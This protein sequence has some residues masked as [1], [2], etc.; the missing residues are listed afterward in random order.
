MSE[1]HPEGGRESRSGSLVSHDGDEEEKVAA[2]PESHAIQSG[3]SRASWGDADASK[4]APATAPLA[5]SMWDAEALVPHKTVPCCPFPRSGGEL[6]NFVWLGG[7]PAAKYFPLLCLV[8]PDW[9]CMCVTYLLIIGPS[10]AFLVLVCVF[11]RP[12]RSRCRQLTRAIPPQ[13]AP[14]KCTSPSSSSA[15]CCW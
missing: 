4:P 11:R 13:S 6:G 7:R 2:D 14:P 1:V 15:S 3:S 9:V 5:E 8:G 12:R 10:V